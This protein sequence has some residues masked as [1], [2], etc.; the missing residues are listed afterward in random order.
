MTRPTESC[1]YLR[2]AYKMREPFPYAG[3]ISK[4][5]EEQE[6][7]ETRKARESCKDCK[8]CK[9]CKNKK[10][11]KKCKMCEKCYKP[12]KERKAH[13]A[14]IKRMTA[15]FMKKH[16]RLFKILEE[17][18]RPYYER[19]DFNEE[20]EV[21]RREDVEAEKIRNSPFLSDEEKRLALYEIRQRRVKRKLEERR[22]EREL[23]EAEKREADRWE[24][25]IREEEERR[26][27]LTHEKQ[28]ETSDESDEDNELN[29][30][31][32]D[33]EVTQCEPSIFEEV[34]REFL[35]SAESDS[36]EE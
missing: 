7:L 36:D 12:I 27:K 35:N 20:E 1:N 28:C 13:E 9:D 18:G 3:I 21:V 34:M 15:N 33:S 31:N 25:E 5:R 26:A 14:R 19:E 2:V 32:E 8:V 23:C 17:D 30:D 11:C 24:R 16:E 22:M 6:I 10:N 29:E 4:A